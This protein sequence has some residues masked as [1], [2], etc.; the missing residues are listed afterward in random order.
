MIADVP[1]E[2]RTEHMSNTS[3]ERYFHTRLFRGNYNKGKETSTY[4]DAEG[5]LPFAVCYISSTLHWHM[6]ICPKGLSVMKAITRQSLPTF[7][8][9]EGL[10]NKM[11]TTERSRLEGQALQLEMWK[12]SSLGTAFH[13]HSI[14]VFMLQ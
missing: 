9:G 10:H 8:K 5:D 3:L 11:G 14:V 1:A 6:S 13:D 4:D 12:R 2:I 7:P